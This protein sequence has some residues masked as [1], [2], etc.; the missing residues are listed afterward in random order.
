MFKGV[1]GW[2]VLAVSVT[3]VAAGGYYFY[4]TTVQ[5]TVTPIV[6]PNQLEPPASQAGDDLNKK[7]REGIGSIKDL[8]PVEI[9][10]SDQKPKK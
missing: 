4:Q 3:V 6:V 1:L 7:R 2:I 8:K 5:Q 10:S 9:P